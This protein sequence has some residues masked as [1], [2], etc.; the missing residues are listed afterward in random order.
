MICKGD[1]DVV[2][3]RQLVQVDGVYDKCC[4]LAEEFLAGCEVEFIFS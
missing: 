3:F 1:F 2:G 4:W